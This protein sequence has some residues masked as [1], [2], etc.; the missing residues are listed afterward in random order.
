MNAP[1][2]AAWLAARKRG[3]GGS[4]ISV[5]LGLNPWKSPVD[6]W[7]DKTG[8]TP[9]SEQNDAMYWGNVLEDV[10][11]REYARRTGNRVQRINRMAVHPARPWMLANIDRAIVA[12]GSRARIADNGGTLLGA[13]GLL[14]CKTASAYK[15]SDW[16]TE[17][18]ADAIPTH[19]VAQCQWYM[20]VTGAP[21]CDIAVLIGGNKY[22]YK[23]IDR[24]AETISA[25]VD[26][27]EAFWFEHVVADVAPE[28]TNARETA[29][30]YPRD[31]GDAIEASTDIAIKVTKLAEIKQQIKILEADE[32]SLADDIKTFLGKHSTLTIGGAPLAT[33]KAPKPGIK[34]D[35]QAVAKEAGV[36]ADIIA[37]HTTTTQGARRLLLKE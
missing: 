10:V 25:M 21:W 17:D 34:T 5:I 8:R 2:R 19:Y 28:P 29:A 35:W 1:D 20:G 11:A 37:A 4:D 31:A 14:E 7:M 30:L 18:D 32:T 6:L 3:I 15:A 24:D 27:A 22:L 23:R 36:S 13:D 26:R 9:D 12:N 33:W 16:G